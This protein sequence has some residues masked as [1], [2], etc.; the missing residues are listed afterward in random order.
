MDVVVL[1]GGGR[2]EMNRPKPVTEIPVK[3]CLIAPRATAEPLDWSDLTSDDHVLYRDP[4]RNF[5]FQST[6]QIRTPDGVLWSVTGSPKVWPLGVEV[7]LKKMNDG[8]FK[9]SRYGREI[10]R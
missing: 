3:D 1:R 8:S 9:C 6:D 7:P 5:S 4:D 10:P 2:D